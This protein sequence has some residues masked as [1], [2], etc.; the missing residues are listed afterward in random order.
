[1]VLQRDRLPE[2]YLSE[3]KPCWKVFKG[4]VA[5]GTPMK[6]SM[7]DKGVK[8]GLEGLE[9]FLD[10]F[11][12]GQFTITLHT[13][14]SSKAVSQITV[15]LGG[16]SSS[17]PVLKSETSFDQMLKM[18]QLVQMQSTNQMGQV[19]EMM[20]QQFENRRLRRE[21]EEGEP[22]SV[23]DAAL[24]QVIEGIGPAIKGIFGPKLPTNQAQLGTL[25]QSDDQDTQAGSITQK[26]AAPAPGSGISVD[27]ILIDLQRIQKAIPEVHIN[28]LVRGFAEWIESD[29]ETAKGML[30][31]LLQQEND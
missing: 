12:S 6:S 30:H 14:Q 22:M 7:T 15:D 28:V 9:L 25:G 4:R 3:N 8:Q 17:G 21:L 29:P 20:E 13:G 19:R 31:Q 16:S 1:M 26:G 18:F 2:Y 10:M 23:K 11:D 5:G 24:M 27:A